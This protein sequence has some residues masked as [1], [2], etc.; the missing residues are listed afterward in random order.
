MLFRSIRVH[1]I[2]TRGGDA[3][4][5]VPAD[6]RLE[7]FVRGSTIRA[8]QDADAKV[9]RCLRA[10][11]MAMGAT[12]E[13]VTLPGYMPLACDPNLSQITLENCSAVVGA[14]HVG[15]SGHATGSTDLGDLGYVMPVVHPRTAGAKGNGHGNDYWTVDQQ[16]AAVNPAKAMAMTAIDLLY[17]GAREARRVKAESEIGRAHV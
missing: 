2:I 5:A 7:T 11:A 16:L 10:G 15:V 14:E 1:P 17:D 8:I 6:V 12:V 9:D 13:I 4:S 3:V